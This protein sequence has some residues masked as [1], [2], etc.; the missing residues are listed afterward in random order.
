M[1]LKKMPDESDEFNV[2]LVAIVI[3]SDHRLW[4]Q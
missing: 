4:G 1:L 2:I 3:A